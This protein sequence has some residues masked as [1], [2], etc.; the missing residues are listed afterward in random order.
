M[1]KKREG[2]S[3]RDLSV[4]NKALPGREMLKVCSKKK[5]KEPLWKQEIMGMSE[6]E[7]AVRDLNFS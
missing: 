7:Q 6:E 5:K 1:D 4:F 3:T 2:F